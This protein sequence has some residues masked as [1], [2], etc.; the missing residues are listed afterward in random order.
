M[1]LIMVFAWMDA[2]QITAFY[3]IEQDDKWELYNQYTAP[4]IIKLWYVVLAAIAVVWYIFSKDIS[5]ALGLFAGSFIMMLFG[6]ED[7]L[8]FVFSSEPMTACMTW[9]G[10]PHT[11]VASLLGQACV[12]PMVLFIDAVLGIVIAY[13]VFNWL[14]KYE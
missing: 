6:L 9:F 8:F 3:H 13:L 11:E 2:L 5:E 10:F 7:L 4:A 12:S 14:K 1:I